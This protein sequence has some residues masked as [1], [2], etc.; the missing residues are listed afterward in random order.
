MS[1]RGLN[2]NNPG[3]I[4]KGGA[5]FEGEIDSSD[6]RFRKFQNIDY[7]YR[8][9]FVLLD[10]YI[11]K[12]FNTIEKIITRYAPSIENNTLAY[13]QS[14]VKQTGISAKQVIDKTETDKLIKLVSAISYHENGIKADI[15]AI[16]CGWDLIKKKG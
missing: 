12:G 3:N 16:K 6:V 7:G 5:K 13:I 9:M 10:S 4:V 11:S 14:V 2:N 1:T 8:A 15:E